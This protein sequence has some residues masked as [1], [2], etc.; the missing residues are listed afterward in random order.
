M[1]TREPSSDPV[2]RISV[3][4][5]AA[6]LGIGAL[7]VGANIF[8]PM[9]LGIVVGVMTAPI[10]DTLERIG[11]R[12]GLAAAL[13]LIAGVSAVTILAIA[14]EPLI[15]NVAG[16]LPRIKHE[17]RS[18]VEEVRGFIRSLGEMNR[19]VEKALGANAG[20]EAPNV[21]PS[22]IPNFTDV[23]IFAPI[24]MMQ[25]LIFGGT[26]FFFLLTRRDMYRGLSRTIGGEDATPVLLHR[27]TRVERLV[28]RYFLTISIINAGLGAALGGVLAIIGLPGPLLWALAAA[29]LNFIIYVGP[30]AVAGSLLLAGLYTFNGLM[31]VVPAAA[32]ICL[33]MLE[34]QFVTPALVGKHVS[35]NPLLVFVS[36]VVWLWLW[37]PVGGIIAIP[38]LVFVLQMMN[39]FDDDQTPAED[40]A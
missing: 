36:L 25:A 28:S 35:V 4:L 24:F 32:F 33:N 16:D 2:L 14:V 11:L 12:R 10:M 15:Q 18:A 19:E 34:A 13:V 40:P 31:V 6:T 37:G 27:F 30:M 3:I 8:A 9:V 39:L 21:D 20:A 23:L 29:L 7:K 38:V 1:H 17:L 26:L 22:E 5:I